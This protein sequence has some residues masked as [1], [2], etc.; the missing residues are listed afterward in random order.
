[1]LGYS[2]NQSSIQSFEHHKSLKERVPVKLHKHLDYAYNWINNRHFRDAMDYNTKE[3]WTWLQQAMVNPPEKVIAKFSNESLSNVSIVTRID[4]VAAP[5]PPKCRICDKEIAQTTYEKCKFSI[6]IC[7]C[8]KK[9]CHQ[10]CAEKYVLSNAQCSLCKSYFI[11]S[12][13]CSSLRSTI[14]M[15]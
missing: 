9:Y 8:E 13:C 5:K 1:M 15:K 4:P 7:K 10:S 2:S 14:A 3:G 11:L 12:P 6:I